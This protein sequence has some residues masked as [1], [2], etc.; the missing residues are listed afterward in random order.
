MAKATRK[1]KNS[2]LCSFRVSGSC[3]QR[4][5][6][7]GAGLVIQVDQ[8]DQHEDR[9]EERVDEELQRRV[10]AARPAPDADEDEH[11]DQHGLEED[12]EQQRVRRAEHAD[13]QPLQHQHG[14]QVL[15]RLVVLD[16]VPGA[17]DDQH[18]DEAGQQ[19]QR[20]RDAVHAQRVVDVERGDP[21]MR[22]DQ[23]HQR[24][25]GVVGRQQEQAGDEGDHGDRQRDP[26]A[27]SAARAG[28]QHRHGAGDGQPD[29]QAKQMIRHRS[30]FLKRPRTTRTRPGAGSGRGSWRTRS[31]RGSPT[32]GGARHRRCAAPGWPNRRWRRR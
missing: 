16:H 4:R 25:I 19:D 13:Q 8:A 2:Q 26:A 12:V 29:Q 6:V 7:E 20:H 31:D 24:A 21:R 27:G 11:R 32:A 15:M 28:D 14:G 30:L 17:D 10:D 18:P 1:A 5:H 22:L 23:L 3:G 9:A